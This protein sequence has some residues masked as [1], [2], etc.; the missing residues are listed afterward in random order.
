MDTLRF[1]QLF[2]TSTLAGI[3]V[4]FAGQSAQA[5]TIQTTSQTQR[6]S[7]ATVIQP[8][9]QP[10]IELNAEAD[11][12]DSASSPLTS[13]QAD[14]LPSQ[15]TSV[16]NA[17]TVAPPPPASISA[18]TL[19]VETQTET[20]AAQTETPQTPSSIESVSEPNLTAQEVAPGRATRSGSSYIGIGGN[21]GFGGDSG[22]GTGNFA[23]LSKVGITRNLSIRPAAL[24]G[25]GL[26][27]LLPATVDFPIA[28]STDVDN[29]RI[30]FAPFIGGGVAIDTD[31]DGNVQPLVTAGV[32]VP[33]TNQFTANASVNVSFPDDTE[34]GVILG[35]GYN[36][37]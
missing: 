25:D 30:G 36:F 3:L 14:P 1:K 8:T 32:D 21:I 34:V 22:L 12:I 13:S 26:T 7:E 20:N 16:T 24:V 33:I 17:E 10:T 29:A 9:I 23:I 11:A 37:R 35:I 19:Q 18:D 6:S 27:F 5:E 2:F 4:A 31:N 15:P 28:A